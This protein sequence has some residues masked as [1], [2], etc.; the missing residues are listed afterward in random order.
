MT[1]AKQ[2]TQT[3]YGIRHLAK[4][5]SNK[6][7]YNMME[8]KES[9]KVYNSLVEENKYYENNSLNYMHAFLTLGNL[10]SQN[11]SKEDK[12]KY[13]ERIV[14][15]TMKANIPNWEKPNNWDTLPVNERLK[16]L[17]KLETLN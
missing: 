14:F 10:T 16:R 11:E 8:G 13:K 2:M 17:N 5:V 6:E 1:T 15:A 4:K 9:N 12:L 3:S 7:M